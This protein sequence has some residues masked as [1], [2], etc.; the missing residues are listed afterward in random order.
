[1]PFIGAGFLQI[2]IVHQMFNQMSPE[3]TVYNTSRKEV[4]KT[5]K[6]LLSKSGVVCQFAESKTARQRAFWCN[7]KAR[8]P[9][10]RF[11]EK[12]NNIYGQF[13]SSLRN[14]FH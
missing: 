1:M 11:N 8:T 13:S 6:S 5:E 10:P 12:K 7:R 9:I 2:K 4:Q 3:N 14:H